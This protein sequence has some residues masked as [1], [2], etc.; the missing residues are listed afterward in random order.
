MEILGMTVFMLAA[1]TGNWLIIGL[2]L[3][4]LIKVLG[5]VYNPGVVL[6]QCVLGKKSWKE[7]VKYIMYEIIGVII[8]VIIY[9]IFP[10]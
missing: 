2:T 6:G 7:G 10:Y 4:V 1:L 5:G 3:C 9:K 8:A